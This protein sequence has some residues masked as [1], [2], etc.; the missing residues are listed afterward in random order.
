MYSDGSRVVDTY[1]EMSRMNACALNDHVARSRA[2][3]ASNN[4]WYGPAGRTSTHRTFHRPVTSRWSDGFRVVVALIVEP[5]P[6]RLFA[7]S[8]SSPTVPLTPTCVIRR[9]G[10]N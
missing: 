1:C 7:K 10:L 6:G 5:R 8:T 3:W 9:D 4:R 2:T